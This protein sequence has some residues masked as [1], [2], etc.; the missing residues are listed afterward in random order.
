MCMLGA[1]EYNVSLAVVKLC[2]LEVP[3]EATTQ[4]SAKEEEK[5]GALGPCAS[6]FWL[7]FHIG[8]PYKF[9]WRKDSVTNQLVKTTVV[10][11]TALN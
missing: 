8:T 11:E 6:F 7:V 1:S 2:S 3:S 5:Y 4:T 9:A 10:M